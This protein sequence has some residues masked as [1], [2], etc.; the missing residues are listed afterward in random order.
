[1]RTIAILFLASTLS[2]A[3]CIQLSSDKIVAGDI[4]K[5]VPV[6][7]I[8]DPQTPIGFAPLPGVQRVL[9]PRD[10][11][12]AAR[13]YQ[14][15]TG[16]QLPSVC[17]ERAVRPL[18][19]DDV[20]AAVRQ[21][22]ALPD[23]HLELLDFG[24]QPAPPGQLEFLLPALP[25]PRADVPDKSVVWRGRLIY[26]GHQSVSVWAR[27]R[28]TADR[29]ILIAAE[30]IAAGAVIAAAQVREVESPEFPFPGA[31]LTREQAAGKVARRGIAAG[32]KLTPEM[33][34]D[35]KEVRS[36]DTVRVRVVDG[37]AT[38]ALDAV[39]Q[40]SGNKGEMVQ[41]HNPSTGKNFRALVEDKNRVVVNTSETE[42]P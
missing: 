41:V 27:I 36:G 20:L 1:M 33:L 9:S 3:D 24:G 28:L 5:V 23:A 38:L 32:E 21:A 4:A 6:F 16:T 40:T 34:S 25:K 42:R 7:Q 11:A 35:P 29:R 26:D 12:L 17:V 18:S 22:L 14:L 8:L 15:D 10:L 39:A 2:R 13:R 30:S 37:L 19:R 31:S